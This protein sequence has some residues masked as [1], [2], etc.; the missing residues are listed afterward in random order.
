MAIKKRTV[1]NSSRQRLERTEFNSYL[2]PK[3]GCLPAL[4][5]ERRTSSKPSQLTQLGHSSKKP[6]LVTPFIEK[7]LENTVK[8]TTYVEVNSLPYKAILTKQQSKHEN[9]AERIQYRSAERCPHCE[10]CF[11]IKA[12]DRH[13]EW[14]R[15]K[16]LQASIKKNNTKYQAA[17]KERLEA[18]IKYKAPCLKTKRSINRDKYSYQTDQ[19]DKNIESPNS[20]DR[21]H[22]DE[23]MTSSLISYSSTSCPNDPFLSAKRQLEDLCSPSTPTSRRH[24]PPHLVASKTSS[25]SNESTLLESEPTSTNSRCVFDNKKM[26]SHS[27]R[28]SSLRK[29]PLS[30]PYKSLFSPSS[31]NQG[32]SVQCG[33]PDKKPISSNFLKAEEYDEI[34]IRT[35]NVDNFSISNTVKC[36]R[37]NSTA[38]SN[39]KKKDGI[40]TNYKKH[41]DKKTEAIAASTKELKDKRNILSKQK[42]QLIRDKEYIDGKPINICDNLPM[43]SIND[44]AES[45]F[46][47]PNSYNYQFE[48]NDSPQLGIEKNL[49]IEELS[50]SLS[51]MKMCAGNNCS[52][53]RHN[54]RQLS[55]RIRLSRNQFLYENLPDNLDNV[56]YDEKSNRAFMEHDKQSN[57]DQL[58]NN[59]TP[60][61][62]YSVTNITPFSPSHFND[63]FQCFLFPSHN[64]DY[65][66]QSLSKSDENKSIDE[67]F[68]SVEADQ[69]NAQ[70]DQ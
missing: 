35:V 28:N 52:S 45:L 27:Q 37:D 18:R 48:Y 2:L 68:I 9:I 49:W 64:H 26:R 56:A 4:H 50:N 30:K 61:D 25:M 29:S 57:S 3:K 38:I 41:E 20:M 10:R 44:L 32:L 53:S 63:F 8:S 16:T 65:N 47:S 59:N 5:N 17:A 31:K 34:P 58:S 7:T 23:L 22:L 19:N 54:N 14:C 13:V 51:S 1:F 12:Y 24:S 70:I 39:C 46:S 62:T 40:A 33:L 60:A 36:K 21:I 67:I 15:E 43:D 42:P 69:T 55:R 66:F 11:G 6:T